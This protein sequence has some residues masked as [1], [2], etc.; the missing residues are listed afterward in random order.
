MEKWCN[1]EMV[2]VPLTSDWVRRRQEEPWEFQVI[3][4]ESA[5][6]KLL[7]ANTW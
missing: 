2:D 5:W 7:L 6:K 4:T 3:S 1:N